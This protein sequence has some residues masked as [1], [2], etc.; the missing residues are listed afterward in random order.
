MKVSILILVY[1]NIT[2][3]KD[4]IQS[5]KRISDRDDILE[6]L[7]LDNG[8]RQSVVDE[9]KRECS[10]DKCSLIEVPSNIGCCAG[11][12]VLL[13]KAAGSHILILDS[14]AIIVDGS[15]IDIAN[16]CLQIPGV[17]IVGDYGGNIRSGWS[18]G[19]DISGFDESKH[20]DQVNGFCQFFSREV[21]DAGVCM[22]T[23]YGPAWLEDLDWCFQIRSKL[24]LRA[25][26]TPLPVLH[27]WTGTQV[28]SH[29]K[30][31][32]LLVLKWEDDPVFSYLAVSKRL[33]KINPEKYRRNKNNRYLWWRQT[34]SPY[35][36]VIYSSLSEE[37]QSI[38]AE[39][40]EDTDPDGGEM[41]PPMMSYLYAMI[42]GSNLT[43][44]VQLGTSRGYSAI[45]LGFLMRQMHAI[46]SFWSIEIDP[47]VNEYAERW[48]RKARLDDYVL[49]ECGDSKDRGI[50]E[51]AIKFL[52]G[53]P[54][55]VVIDSSHEYEQ[56]ITELDLWY[57][58]LQKHGFIVLHDASDQAA[59]VDSTNSGGVAQA[60][61]DW[62]HGRSGMSCIRI[63]PKG[64]SDCH[65]DEWG[66]AVIQK[67]EA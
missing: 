48:I 59:F 21:I 42:S 49:L 63:N 66:M 32:K 13:R 36:P 24:G 34:K 35:I 2:Q 25:Y 62:T 43:K 41:K 28:K 6:I 64:D 10:F 19:F 16:E 51:S 33:K 44:V 15:L 9:L 54:S 57:D 8:S 12:D 65:L 5:V 45:M 56:T 46:D 11:R 37:E 55:L 47:L 58:L 29:E 50:A 52:G 67:E 53:R 27:Q 3:A 61:R 40:F 22:D 39:W 60:L 4:C 17:G 30:M 38:V 7:V 1:N 14:D 26:K 18:V 20:V 23:S 31:W